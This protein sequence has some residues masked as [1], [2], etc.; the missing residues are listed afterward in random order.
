MLEAMSQRAT[1]A[2]SFKY[3]G[4]IPDSFVSVSAS[5]GCAYTHVNRKVLLLAGEAEKAVSDAR[6][7]DPGTCVVRKIGLSGPEKN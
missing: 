1:D 5:I 7:T 2:L 3:P 4:K 6:L